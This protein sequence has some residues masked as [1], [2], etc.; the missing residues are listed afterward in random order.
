MTILCK[1]LLS[2]PQRAGVLNLFFCDV[3]L[4]GNLVNPL[5]LSQNGFQYIK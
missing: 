3:D 5:V 4:Y 2:D 1:D